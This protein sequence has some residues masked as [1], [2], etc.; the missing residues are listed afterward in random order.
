MAAYC[1][2]GAM[3]HAPGVPFHAAVYSR[4]EIFEK[5]CS[6]TYRGQD[7]CQGE[8]KSAGILDSFG[9]TRASDISSD[10]EAATLVLTFPEPCINVPR[11]AIS[12]IAKLDHISLSKVARLQKVAGELAHIA[13]KFSDGKIGVRGLRIHSKFMLERLGESCQS[14]FLVEGYDLLYYISKR[15]NRWIHSESCSTLSA[16]FFLNHLSVPLQVTRRSSSRRSHLLPY[17]PDCFARSLHSITLQITPLTGRAADGAKIRSCDDQEIIPSYE[18]NGDYLILND[19]ETNKEAPP[20]KTGLVLLVEVFYSRNSLCFYASGVSLREAETVNIVTC[21]LFFQVKFESHADMSL[22]LIEGSSAWSE[23]QLAR[24]VILQ[25]GSVYLTYHAFIK[26]LSVHNVY[27]GCLI[28]G[29]QDEVSFAE[30]DTRLAFLISA[31]VT[32]QLTPKDAI[33]RNKLMLKSS[34]YKDSVFT[35][36]EVDQYFFLEELG[37]KGLPNFESS[38]RHYETYAPFHAGHL[39]MVRHVSR[40]TLRQPLTRDTHIREHTEQCIVDLNERFH[41]LIGV[42]KDTFA[43]RLGYGFIPVIGPSNFTIYL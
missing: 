18:A 12:L 31:A 20:S 39:E 25:V 13:V 6:P 5:A 7:N 16:D 24:A 10:D 2:R 38:R 21:L 29:G 43:V 34:I 28:D 33:G 4:I 17:A 36:I 41:I 42:Y 1:V 8:E 23:F 37:D 22:H 30:I 35:K 9:I 27:I 26:V 32:E 3:L 14:E 19:G 40:E 15:F 11:F